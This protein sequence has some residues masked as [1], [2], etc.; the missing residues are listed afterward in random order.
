MFKMCHQMWPQC[1]NVNRHLCPGDL[2]GGHSDGPAR[3]RYGR[4]LYRVEHLRAVL[5]G[6]N[7]WKPDKDQ[8]NMK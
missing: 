6:G 7:D 4:A 5:N 1:C 8:I 2:R 3:Q